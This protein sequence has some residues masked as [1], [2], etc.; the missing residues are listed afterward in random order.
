MASFKLTAD[1]CPPYLYRNNLWSSSLL[2]HSWTQSRP[3][4][5]KF[6]Q[7]M[8]CASC[9]MT[10][11]SQ[12]SSILKTLWVLNI[13]PFNHEVTQHATLSLKS[14]TFSLMLPTCP[15]SLPDAYLLASCSLF[16]PMKNEPSKMHL[17]RCGSQANHSLIASL[18]K[19]EKLSFLWSIVPMNI[20]PLN[21]FLKT[22]G[23]SRWLLNANSQ[24]NL[25]PSW[26]I[27]SLT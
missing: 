11:L 12:D 7:P 21:L 5:I 1:T 15:I 22:L 19:L 24:E 8:K 2:A 18:I 27:P 6:T 25:F 14:Y 26:C 4:A 16:S 20:V 17:A 10:P 13:D 23:P 9:S 3:Y